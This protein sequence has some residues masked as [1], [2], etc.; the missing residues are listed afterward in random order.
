MPAIG[1]ILRQLMREHH[2]GNEDEIIKTIIPLGYYGAARH[3]VSVGMPMTEEAIVEYLKGH[4][5][6]EY[7]HKIPAKSN[8]I[9][10]LQKLQ[11]RGLTLHILTAC[12]HA[13]MDPCLNRLGIYELFG[14]VWSTDDLDM[15]KAD[16]EIYRVVANKIGVPVEELM[17]LDDNFDADKTAKK[18]GVRVCGVFDEASRAFEED[19]KLVADHYIYDFSELLDLV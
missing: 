4:M 8:V 15:T 11:E 9:S 17:F 1:S 13:M 19:I 2:I 7:R 16:P 18:A 12:P 14:N 6:G 5:G 3:L 10:V